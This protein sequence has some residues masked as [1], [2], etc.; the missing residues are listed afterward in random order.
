MGTFSTRDKLGLDLVAVN[1]QV[2]SSKGGGVVGVTLK[3]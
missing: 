2:S 1:S 3:I